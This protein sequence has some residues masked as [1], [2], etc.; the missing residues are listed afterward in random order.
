MKTDNKAQ[1]AKRKANKIKG[2]ADVMYVYFTLPNSLDYWPQGK[3]VKRISEQSN[4][5]FRLGVAIKTRGLSF[6]YSQTEKGFL[7]NWLYMGVV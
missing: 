6:L 4:A 5:S 3:A 1:V 2:S 7:N